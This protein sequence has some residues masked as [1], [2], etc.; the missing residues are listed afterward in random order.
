EHVLGEAVDRVLAIQDRIERERREGADPDQEGMAHRCLLPAP[1]RRSAAARIG[2]FPKTIR[3]RMNRW[4]N[5]C[6]AM[7][8][9]PKLGAWI[10]CSYS[11]APRMP[12]SIPVNW[13]ES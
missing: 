11:A 5:D 9:T 7:A 8:V 13:W 4:A 12:V 3:I 1:R 10:I 2:R 6:P